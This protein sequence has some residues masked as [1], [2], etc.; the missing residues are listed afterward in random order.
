MSNENAQKWF[1]EHQGQIL[2]RLET[3]KSHVEN[4]LNESPESVNWASVGSIG[5]LNN[6]LKEAEDFIFGNEE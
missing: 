5:Q 6:M 3:L 1:L 2:K 4:H